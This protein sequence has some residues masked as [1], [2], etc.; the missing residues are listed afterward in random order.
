M[1]VSEVTAKSVKASAPNLIMRK[2][3]DL[4]PSVPDTSAST[5]SVT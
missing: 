1:V 2:V 5:E 3:T 4:S